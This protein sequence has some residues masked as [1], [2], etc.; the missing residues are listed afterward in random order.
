MDLMPLGASSNSNNNNNNSASANSKIPNPPSALPNAKGATSQLPSTSP[1][2]TAGPAGTSAAGRGHQRR[3]SKV[4]NVLAP[5]LTRKKP[6]LTAMAGHS[7][8]HQAARPGINTT[9][10]ITTAA[11]T[12]THSR[13]ASSFI[14]GAS[15]GG[16][17][18]DQ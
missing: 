6:G 7:Q 4:P 3:L 16:G 1:R 12:T 8:Q 15:N 5:T 17:S 2:S 14:P 10:T 13:T 9:T 11:P 18:A